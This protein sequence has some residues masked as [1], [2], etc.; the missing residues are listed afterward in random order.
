ME[1]FKS[2]E[3][4]INRFKNNI[5]TDRTSLAGE[6]FDII[7]MMGEVKY[8]VEVKKLIGHGGSSLVYEVYVDD[9]YPPVKKMIMKEVHLIN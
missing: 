6:K 8:A 2:Q 1:S 4:I 7:S 9:N 3:E 5:I